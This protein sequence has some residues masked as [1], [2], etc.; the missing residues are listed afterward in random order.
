MRVY[1]VTDSITPPQDY[2][3]IVALNISVGSTTN[4]TVNATLHYP[5]QLPAFEMAPY[6][7]LQNGT[8]MPLAYQRDTGT[9]TVT[10]TV[11]LDPIVALLQEYAQPTTITSTSTVS[12]TTTVNAT[13]KTAPVQP[14][15]PDVYVAAGAAIVIVIILALAAHLLRKKKPKQDAARKH[16]S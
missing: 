1:N 3:S 2:R 13:G 6:E 11:P 4:V 10:A 14:T 8:W 7:L 9:C 16:R 5:C 15:S 12:T